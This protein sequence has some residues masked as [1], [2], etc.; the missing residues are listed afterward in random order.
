MVDGLVELVSLIVLIIHKC[1]LVI[2]YIIKGKEFKKISKYIFGFVYD[3]FVFFISTSLVG[4]L[5][6]NILLAQQSWASLAS[7]IDHA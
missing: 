4:L 2:Y 3:A 7:H 5:L 1:L 6:G